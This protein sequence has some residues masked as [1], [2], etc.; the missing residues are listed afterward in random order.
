[1]A[2][3]EP[4]NRILVIDLAFIGDVMLAT[5]VLRALRGSYP[6]ARITM[7]TLQLTAEVAAM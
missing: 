3:P 7:L 5:P 1:M 6:K 2:K 4:I